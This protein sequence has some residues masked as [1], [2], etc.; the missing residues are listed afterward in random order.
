MKTAVYMRPYWR[1]PLLGTG[2]RCP[3]CEKTFRPSDD[4]GCKYGGT[5]VCSIPCMRE[6]AAQVAA[7]K[8]AKIKKTKQY[9]AWRMAEAGKTREEIAAAF[10]VPRHKTDWYIG[11]F[12]DVHRDLL[13]ELRK[14]TA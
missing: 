6:M 9:K 2:Q 14:E 3:V 4:W 10:G 7:K 8:I 1:G 5:L 12:M 11:H 13:D